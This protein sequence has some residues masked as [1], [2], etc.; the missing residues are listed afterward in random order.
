MK[1]AHIFYPKKTDKFNLT[2]DTPYPE[3]PMASMNIPESQ[4]W[5]S[6]NQ[7][8]FEQHFGYALSI[9]V[10]SQKNTDEILE[11]IFD[12]MNLFNQIDKDE[13]IK[14]YHKNSL[15]YVSMSIGAIIEY[16]GE[17][18]MVAPIGFAKIN[19]GNVDLEHANLNIK[20]D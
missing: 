11:D 2:F 17:Y 7:L 19:N 1:T 14:N 4:G 8:N 10:D 3:L 20:F 5:F 15:K 18:Y 13:V 6:V 9:K 12:E 16:S